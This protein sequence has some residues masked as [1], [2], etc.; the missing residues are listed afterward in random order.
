[1][2]KPK[3]TDRVQDSTE[4][5]KPPAELPNDPLT[6][7]VLIPPGAE[8]QLVDEAS[9]GI[10]ARLGRF[11]IRKQ[12]G[13]GG[14]GD[15][16][17]GFDATLKRQVAIKCPKGLQ[18]ESVIQTFLAEAQRLAQLQHPGIVVIHDI[19]RDRNRC[20]IVTEF[21]EG[22]VLDVLPDGRPPHWRKSVRIVSHLADALGHAHSRG[23]MH[24]DIK[25]SN[26]MMTIDGRCVLLDFGLAV[27]DLEANRGEIA[28][29]P[30][31]MSPEQIRGESHLIDGRTDI[32]AM[33]VILYELLTGRQPF[34]SPNR[35][36][37]FRK[38]LE[39]APQPIRQL[40]PA[41][42]ESIEVICK[43]A[44]SKNRDDRYTTAYD[45]A[46]ALLIAIGDKTSSLSHDS[47]ATVSPTSDSGGGPLMAP[48]IAASSAQGDSSHMRRLKDAQL[49][50]VTL[51][52]VGFDVSARG[53]S[54]ED[55]HSLSESFSS[56]ILSFAESQ[57]GCVSTTSGNEVEI[58]FG[59]PVAYEDSLLRAIRCG[60]EILE[61]AEHRQTLPERDE[62]LIAIDSGLTVA[63]ET[64]DG[65]K[66][67]GEIRQTLRRLMA[68]VTPGAVIVT[69]T[70]HKS[71]RVYFEQEPLGAISIRG[72]AEPLSL[73]RVTKE[74]PITLNRVEL[75]DPGNLTPLIGRDTEFSILKDR[76]EQTIEEMGQIVL[77]I[78]EAGLG[79]SRLIREIREHVI[80]QGLNPDVIELRCSQ[81][82]QS[83]GLHPMVEHLTQLLQFDLNLSTDSRLAAIER[84]LQ[85]LSLVSDQ[86]RVLMANLLEVDATQLPPL[87]ANAQ[88]KRELTGSFLLEMLKKRSALRPVLFIVEDLHWVDPT[89]LDLLTVYVENFDQNRALSIFTFR[90]EFETPWRSKPHQTQIALNRLTKR[91]IRDMMRK[92]LGRED[93][94]AVVVEQIAQRTD[95][96]PFFIEEFSTL[97]AESGSL[98]EASVTAST[99]SQVIPESLQDLLMARLDRMASDPAVIQMAAAIGREFTYS[100]L[101]AA[102]TLAADELQAELKKLVTAEVLFQKGA[103]PDASF[104]FKHALLQ[105]SAYNSLLKKRKFAIHARIGAAIE[106]SFPDMIQHQPELV[107][108]HFTEAGIPEKGAEYW[109]KAG[110][111]AQAVFANIEAI[112]HL[113]C[114][115][116]I[117]QSIQESPERDKLELSM[118]LALAP[119]LMAARGWSAPEVGTSIERS[120]QLVSKFDSLEDKFFVMWGLW[121][122][123]VIR[124]DTDIATPIAEEMMKLARSSPEGTDLLAE[125]CWAVGCSDYYKGVFKTG[126]EVLEKG[127]ELIDAEKERL[128]SLKTGQRCSIMC[129]SHS[130]MALWQMGYPDQALQRSDENARLGKAQNHPFS[131]AM[132]QFFRRQV[133]DF[134]GFTELSR[135]SI[136]E[137]YKICHE[138]GFVFF[139]VHAVFGRGVLLLKEG[140]ANEAREH[141]LQGLEMLKATGGNLSMDHPYSMIAEGYIAA[142]L[143]DDAREW[144]GRGFDLVDNR[145][146]RSRESE[147]LRLQGLVA[148]ATGDQV[149]ASEWFEKAV[150]VA[151][152]QQARSWELR[153]L[154]SFAEL[155]KSQGRSN[156]ARQML[157]QTYRSFSEGHATS[158]LIRASALM[159]ELEVQA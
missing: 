68:V 137:E 19:G 30:N 143:I 117:L 16:F 150:D 157:E 102:S 58:C 88:K 13:S 100:L 79:K 121:G 46:D 145:N 130:A 156:E 138:N 99:L 108:H 44:L 35:T 55:Q 28:G 85:S 78:G 27:N 65:V 7:T 119:V 51:L 29:T 49:R 116:K 56:E 112:R 54:P 93:L 67:T 24:R 12:L 106:S 3:E 142:K 89:L 2:A 86:N 59:F 152:R 107:A 92:R 104:I 41:V 10:P 39:D 110:V 111:K 154:I 14:F 159:T 76:W 127:L 105:D 80:G 158:D 72:V 91:Q 155:R 50:L 75:V 120:R 61:L 60:M 113:N 146:Q 33:G 131:F 124:A 32:F 8:V 82:H 9:E 149:T 144:L 6:G 126:L 81:Y 20:F 151:R 114:G 36:E 83:T 1:M 5:L 37:L 43:K 34:R 109:F 132:S 42:P 26:I 115:L 90:P 11:E 69:E 125:A 45:F 62:L 136:E 25:P 84:Y 141:F 95:G 148:V 38:I 123:R 22:H 96:I 57:G 97:L 94:P 98:D 17:L 101:S 77:L 71:S 40:N 140:K 139:E 18:S 21:L 135:A 64:V 118:Q 48:L 103:F 47:S 4:P 74:A 128:H 129:R 52:S 23:I 66:L 73:Y 153:A 15:V 63:E 134:C 133:L 70:V 53:L 31:Y 87:D 122:W 147:F